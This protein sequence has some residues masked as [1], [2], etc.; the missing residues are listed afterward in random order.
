MENLVHAGD[1]WRILEG[2]FY[3]VAFFSQSVLRHTALFALVRISGELV[4]QQRESRGNSCSLGMNF[5]QRPSSSHNSHVATVK[6]ETCGGK[7]ESGGKTNGLQTAAH[8]SNGQWVGGG[9]LFF[10]VYHIKHGL[11]F[12]ALLHSFVSRHFNDPNFP[13]RSLERCTPE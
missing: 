5:C 9:S 6:V 1:I 7:Q 11:H 10:S 2:A 4:I 13:R 3:T 8:N 12:E